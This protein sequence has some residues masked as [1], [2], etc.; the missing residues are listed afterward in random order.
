MITEEDLV[1]TKTVKV[2]V[3]PPFRVVHE[4]SAYH[5]GDTL[6]VPE[7]TAAEWLASGWVERVSS[8]S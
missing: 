3:Q 1:T 4:A 6:S 5:E 7:H 8:K 2:K